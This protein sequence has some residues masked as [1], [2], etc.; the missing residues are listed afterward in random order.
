MLLGNVVSAQGVHPDLTKVAKIVACP[1]PC[2]AKQFKKFEATGS[3]YHRFLKNIAKI[4]HPFCEYLIDR[5][6]L[7]RTVYQALVWLFRLN[8]SNGNVA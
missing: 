6:F 5:K 7:I 2:K 8:E 3:Y 4:A 1:R